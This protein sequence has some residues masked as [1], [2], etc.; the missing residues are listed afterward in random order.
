MIFKTFKFQVLINNTIPGIIVEQRAL[1]IDQ[2]TKAVQAM[3]KGS[4]VIFY[5]MSDRKN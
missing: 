5:G 3:Y 2:A 1:N 4:K